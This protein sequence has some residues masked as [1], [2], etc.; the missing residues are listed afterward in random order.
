MSGSKTSNTPGDWAGNESAETR[1]MYGRLRRMV[2]GVTSR[3]LWQLIDHVG[4]DGKRGTRDAEVFNGAGMIARP[5]GRNAEAI[6]F[7]QGQGASDPLII[8]IRDQQMAAALQAALTG[9]ELGAGEVALGAGTEGSVECLVHLRTDG[10][11][12]IRTPTGEAKSLVT[13]ETFM[14][15]GHPTAPTGPVTPPAPIAPDVEPLAGTDVIKGE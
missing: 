2:L 5:G 11:V 4:L 7:F 6:V 8:A 1:S 12:E 10:T 9:G 15:H 3:L 13:F 14:R